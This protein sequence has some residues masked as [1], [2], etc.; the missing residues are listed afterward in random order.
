MRLF[1]FGNS[2]LRECIKQPSRAAL[3][4]GL[5]VHK[6]KLV[7]DSKN[8]QTH[9]VQKERAPEKVLQGVRP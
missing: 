5:A 2:A 8:P 6:L 7:G 9:E 4:G 1:H 3:I